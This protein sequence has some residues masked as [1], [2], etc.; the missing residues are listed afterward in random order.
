MIYSQAAEIKLNC[1]KD[2]FDH[3]DAVWN[4][5]LSLWKRICIIEVRLMKEM[6]KVG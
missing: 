4:S 5:L 3:A 6:V 1:F 2:D